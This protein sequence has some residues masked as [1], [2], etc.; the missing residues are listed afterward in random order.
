MHFSLRERCN[1]GAAT[2]IG[3]RIGRHARFGDADGQYRRQ[4]DVK[5]PTQQRRKATRLAGAKPLSGGRVE[6][7]ANIATHR[8]A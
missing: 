4:M 6:Q 3:A 1:G 8:R 7:F 5:K 2:E